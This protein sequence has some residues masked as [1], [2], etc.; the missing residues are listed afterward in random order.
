MVSGG[1][2][3]YESSALIAKQAERNI[4]IDRVAEL[5]PTRFCQELRSRNSTDWS[6]DT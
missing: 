1:A 3:L 2:Y 5:R 4:R 6:V